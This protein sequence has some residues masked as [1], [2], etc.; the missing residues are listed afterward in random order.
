MKNHQQAMRGGDDTLAYAQTGE[1]VLPVEVQDRFPELLQ[2]VLQA[3]EQAGHNP[4]RYMVGSPEG[5]YNPETGA[6]EFYTPGTEATLADLGYSNIGQSAASQADFTR[7]AMGNDTTAKTNVARGSTSII[8]GFNDILNRIIASAGGAGGGTSPAAPSNPNIPDGISATLPGAPSAVPP[9][10]TIGTN[11]GS[12]QAQPT[13]PGVGFL[14][15]FRDRD[16]GRDGYFPINPATQ[17]FGAFFSSAGRRAGFG[18]GEGGEEPTTR[19]FAA[20][21][22]PSVYR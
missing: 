2:I 9:G 13:P 14:G 22:A 10:V 1:V 12:G 16:T 8:G 17:G 11:F 15:R 20:L 3:I 6:Q 4:S 18:G 7:T 19:R 5:S 21:S